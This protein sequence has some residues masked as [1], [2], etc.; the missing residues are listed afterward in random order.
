MNRKPKGTNMHGGGDGLGGFG[1]VELKD[2][3]GI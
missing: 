1:G 2:S 3:T